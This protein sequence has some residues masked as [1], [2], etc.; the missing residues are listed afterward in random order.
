MLA[1]TCENS[2]LTLKDICCNARGSECS[3]NAF[4]FNDF[5]KISPLLLLVNQIMAKLKCYSFVRRVDESVP[6]IRQKIRRKPLN[7]QT[8]IEI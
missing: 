8:P 4:I 1:L 5:L 2:L 3:K 7:P 6:N